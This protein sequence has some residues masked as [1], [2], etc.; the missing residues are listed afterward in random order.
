MLL[1]VIPEDQDTEKLSPHTFSLVALISWGF[2]A[3]AELA[4]LT[5]S[6]PSRMNKQL[7]KLMKQ[8]V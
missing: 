2:T 6:K 5:I 8:E 3:W 1:L 7:G 4:G